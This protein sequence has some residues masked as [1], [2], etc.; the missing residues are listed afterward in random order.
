MLFRLSPDSKLHTRVDEKRDLARHG[1]LWRRRYSAG[2]A[3]I[4][5]LS[6]DG[7]N[8]RWP[9]R[10]RISG[11]VWSSQLFKTLGVTDALRDSLKTFSGGRL[12]SS[13]ERLME[14]ASRSTGG[15]RL[16]WQR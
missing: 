11:G 16:A 15:G 13:A 5:A 8:R 6:P 14:K 4:W 1:V 3:H 2:M 10:A 9:Q 12:A 7:C